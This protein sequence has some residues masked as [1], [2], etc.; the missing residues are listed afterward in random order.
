MAE[1]G[2]FNPGVPEICRLLCDDW[3]D[4]KGVVLRIRRYDFKHVRTT[5]NGYLDRDTNLTGVTSHSDRETNEQTNNLKTEFSE[6]ACELHDII[7]SSRH[8][9]Y[10]SM[11]IIDPETI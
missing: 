9:F 2:L 10:L 3:S 11:V 8:C 1:Y 6:K 7:P 5:T 4:W